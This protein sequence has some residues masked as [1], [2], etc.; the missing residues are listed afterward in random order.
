MIEK[1]HLIQL[2]NQVM[3]FGRY[4]GRV[5]I[6]LPEEYLLWFAQKGFPSGVLG[7][8]LALALEIKVNGQEDL[9]NP[10]R[11]YPSIH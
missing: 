6:D 2:A 9:L 11:D 7:N 3:P 1:N 4:A 10:L 5:L 8:L